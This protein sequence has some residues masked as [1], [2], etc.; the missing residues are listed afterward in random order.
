M[1][2]DHNGEL[3]DDVPPAPRRASIAKSLVN[4]LTREI[5]RMS[6]WRI[7]RAGFILINE[8][9]YAVERTVCVYSDCPIMFKRSFMN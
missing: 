7:R 8:Q 3:S 4:K 9:L 5:H 6:K 2:K 1:I